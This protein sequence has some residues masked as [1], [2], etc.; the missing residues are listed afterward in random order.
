MRSRL[1]RW[2]IG[3][4][5]ALAIVAGLAPGGSQAPVV[6]GAGPTPT[7]TQLGTDSNPGGSG[8]G[9]GGG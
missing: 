4:A 7:P 6:R 5:L 9:G 1:Q 8:G 3:G 2:L